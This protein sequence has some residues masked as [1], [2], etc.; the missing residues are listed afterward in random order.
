MRSFWVCAR[1][2]GK[3]SI[4]GNEAEIECEGDEICTR[5][6]LD[7]EKDNEFGFIFEYENEFDRWFTKCLSTMLRILWRVLGDSRIFDEITVSDEEKSRS[8][9]KVLD[10]I[11]INFNGK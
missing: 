4:E 3:I 8:V 11:F 10:Q 9:V 2:S 7:S 1:G 5:F 6:E